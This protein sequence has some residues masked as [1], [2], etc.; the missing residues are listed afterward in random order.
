MNSY[1]DDRKAINRLKKEYLQHKKLIIG[2]DFDNT[3][4]DYHKENLELTPIINLLKRCSKLKFIMCLYTID[5][6]LYFK[7]TY[8]R[9]LGINIDYVNT[10][11]VILGNGKPY[12]NILLDDRAGLSASYNILLTTLN[13][14]N[15]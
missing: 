6:N 13:E 12:F 9:M 11:P 2:F 4:Y 10:S 14:L 1:L 15:I 7:R 3:I 8:T 5:N